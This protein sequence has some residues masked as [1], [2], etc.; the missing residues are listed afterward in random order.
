MHRRVGAAG[1]PNPNRLRRRVSGAPIRVTY[2]GDRARVPPSL[3]SLAGIAKRL[4]RV[5]RAV[6]ARNSYDSYRPPPGY[7]GAESLNARVRIGRWVNGSG[8]RDGVLILPR[9]GSRCD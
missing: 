4:V 9:E 8:S 5:A 1:R 6:N 3:S 2:P 7:P